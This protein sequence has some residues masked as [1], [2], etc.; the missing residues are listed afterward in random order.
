M[1]S[2]AATQTALNAS[3]QNLW[4]NVITAAPTFIVALVVFSLGLVVA[5]GLGK[6]A[7]KI[8][9]LTKLDALVEKAAAIV[10]LQTLGFT[11]NFSRTV[12]WLVQ[13]FLVVV[14][15]ITVADILQLPQVTTFLQSVALYLP[16]VIVAIV[17]LTIGLILGKF[18]HDVVERGLQSSRM[19]ATAGSVASTAQWAV[20]VFAIMAALTQLGIAA[21]LIEILFAGL[22][23][24]VGL[25]F[26]LAFGLGG[27]DR[28]K[29]WLD[30]LSGSNGKR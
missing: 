15:L 13:W 10:R 26:G 9:R 24:G 6:F 21:R 2:V 19:V 5:G 12:G 25:A 7:A 16:N 17:V 20:V 29:A 3:F 4:N 27:K 14:V 28:A 23:L 18:V 8:I 11:F 30:K 1:V 22:T